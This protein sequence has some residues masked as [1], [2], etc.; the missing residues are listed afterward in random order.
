MKKFLFPVVLVALGTGSAFATKVVKKSSQ[1]LE[2]AYVR[3]DEGGGQFRCEDAAQDC[4]TVSLGP[5]CIWEQ[6]NTTELRSVGSDTMCGNKLHQ[7][8]E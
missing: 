2:A 7:I 6:D 1:S 8:P 5:F 3:I 4:S